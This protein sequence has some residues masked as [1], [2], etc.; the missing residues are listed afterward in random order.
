MQLS[1]SFELR[2]HFALKLISRS[3]VCLSSLVIASVFLLLIPVASLG[4]EGKYNPKMSIGDK[5]PSFEKLPGVDEK[6]Y[7]FADFAKAKVLVVVF[8]CNS[9]PYA[10]DYEERLVQ[11][12]KDFCQ[13]EEVALV[14]INCNLIAADS[15]EKM[16][17]RA[18]E[19]G[20][21][22]PYLFDKSQAIA[23]EY[24]AFRTPEFFVLDQDR[25]IVYM[26]AFDDNSMVDKVKKKYVELAV[27]SV[28]KKEKLD[29]PETAPVGCMIRFKKTRE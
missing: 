5:A 23:K 7:A 24:G 29:D 15:L 9:C 20:F 17:E 8:T 10:V 25:K 1:R 18:D 27:Q 14:A 19:R 3:N 26:G 12:H 6:E 21:K 2:T 22:F 11:F 13:S 4:I 28:L 16:K